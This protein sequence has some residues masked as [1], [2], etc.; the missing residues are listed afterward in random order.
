MSRAGAN[1]TVSPNM[2]GGKRMA[3]ELLRPEIAAFFDEMSRDKHNPQ[4]EEIAI[5]GGS[6]FAGKSV[7]DLPPR[8]DAN[9][10]LLALKDRDKFRYNPPPDSVLN[11]GGV[12]V[13]FGDRARW[14]SSG[15]VRPLDGL[16]RS[17]THA[18]SRSA[19]SDGLARADRFVGTHGDL[20]CFHRVL[21][22]RS[23][24]FA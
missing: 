11:A 7:A 16:T 9:I 8:R 6:P 10:V 18:S 19:Q 23:R 3:S 12:L 4:L 22:G 13:V 14:R 21:G 17:G 24:F 2:I 1:M 20:E 15:A 5:T